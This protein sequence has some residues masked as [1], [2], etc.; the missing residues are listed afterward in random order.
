MIHSTNFW[1]LLLK[2]LHDANLYLNEID[3]TDLN[4]DSFKVISQFMNI[5]PILIGILIAT[6]KSTK[7]TVR[8]NDVH[9]LIKYVHHYR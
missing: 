3:D 2:F 1:I 6:F 4:N 5:I 8:E 7:D 9:K